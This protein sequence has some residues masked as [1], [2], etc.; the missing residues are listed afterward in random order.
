MTN[1]PVVQ[2]DYFSTFEGEALF[3]C[4]S[5]HV[6]CSYVRLPNTEAASLRSV[7]CPALGGRSVRTVVR[8]G[9]THS[10]STGPKTGNRLTMHARAAIA[11]IAIG[12]LASGC[13]N[14]EAATK[15]TT[16]AA[17][18]KTTAKR[19]TP[20]RP[21]TTVKLMTT[22]V[23]TTTRPS[24]TITPKLSADAQA[25]LS[26]YEAYLVAMAAAAHD[27]GRAEQLL[28]PGVTGDALARLIE[29]ARFNVAEGQYWDGTRADILS[30]PRVQSVGVTRSTV[31]DCRSVGG[32][33]RKQSTNAVVPGSTDPDVDDLIV[34]LVKIDG[35][36]LVTRTD[37]TN[38][39]EGKGT[40]APAS[41]P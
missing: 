13:A 34:D 17:K 31:R 8:R 32:V 30:S 21:T 22:T 20:T 10:A 28:P 24:T 15:T 5:D 27:P 6:E 41:S 2:I 36:W 38:A 33:L 3:N 14:A 18:T 26:G 19:T 25:V 16:P 23:A 39:E 9:L 4:E 12:A 37:R 11:L 40:C 35:R 1:H 7:G 29:L